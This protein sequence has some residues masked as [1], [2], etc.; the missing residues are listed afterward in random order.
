MGIALAS[1]GIAA[2]IAIVVPLVSFR[3]ALRQDQAR[4]LREQR[5]QLYVDMLTEALGEEQRLEYTMADDD[6]RERMKSWFTDLRMPALER[7]RLGARGTAYGSKPKGRQPGVQQAGAS[8]L[9]GNAQTQSRRGRPPAAADA[10]RDL[11]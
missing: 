10:A 6:T 2:I 5:T 3:L 8:G 11:A 1:S 4:W 9:P 7:A